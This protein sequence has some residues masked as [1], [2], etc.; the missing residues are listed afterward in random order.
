MIK[1]WLAK[2][3][4]ITALM[5]TPQLASAA[6][7]EVKA[8]TGVEK[9]WSDKMDCESS[10]SGACTSAYFCSND[11]WMPNAAFTRVQDRRY[12]GQQLVIVRDG[13][14]ICAVN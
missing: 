2:T 7:F 5:F 10:A 9:G 3:L 11:I 14:P 6:K 8:A 13:Q 1:H 12:A 4:L